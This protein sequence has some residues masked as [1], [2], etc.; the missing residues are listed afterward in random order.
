MNA[1]DEQALR[2][3]KAAGIWAPSGHLSGVRVHGGDQVYYPAT[4]APYSEGPSWSERTLC[5]EYTDRISTCDIGL[6]AIGGEDPSRPEQWTCE[7]E[8]DDDCQVGS[9]CEA[10]VYLDGIHPTPSLCTW[11]D[12]FEQGP[13]IYGLEQWSDGVRVDARRI[14]MSVPTYIRAFEQVG[15]WNDAQEFEP[16]DESGLAWTVTRCDPESLCH[17][18]GLAEGDEIAF[19]L[20]AAAAIPLGQDAAFT[21]R[22]GDEVQ[23]WTLSLGFD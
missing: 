16:L 8:S 2:E 18:V 9:V 11:S 5:A 19:T 17:H 22:R 13:P 10:G 23:T 3:A 14:R 12:A 6:V 1:L 7:C 20:G 21:V 4:A 15:L